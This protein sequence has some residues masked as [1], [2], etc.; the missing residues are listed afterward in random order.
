ARSAREAA[1]IRDTSRLLDAM[2]A[3]AEVAL[4]RGK[5]LEALGTLDAIIPMTGAAA[6][7]PRAKAQIELGRSDALSM[8]GRFPE[9]AAE[10][11]KALAILEPLAERDRKMR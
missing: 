9:A 4:D 7:E 6:E 3:Q 8:A 11:K 1:D 2:A 10:A 5:P